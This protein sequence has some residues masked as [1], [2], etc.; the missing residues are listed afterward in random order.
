MI[1][2]AAIT[3]IAAGLIILAVCALSAFMLSSRITRL[4]EDHA[5]HR[6]P[7]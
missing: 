7:Q 4:E 5:R 2:I 3:L 6:G 1:K